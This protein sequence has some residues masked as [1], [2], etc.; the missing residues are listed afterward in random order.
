[1]IMEIINF[2]FLIKELGNNL[3]EMVFVCIGSWT[4]EVEQK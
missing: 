4:L 2:D 1:M 3:I